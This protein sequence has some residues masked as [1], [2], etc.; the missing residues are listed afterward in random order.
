MS[1]QPATSFARV[2]FLREKALARLQMISKYPLNRDLTLDFKSLA[3]LKVDG[4]VLTESILA[5]YSESD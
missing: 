3:N 4:A 5:D 2:Q 1:S